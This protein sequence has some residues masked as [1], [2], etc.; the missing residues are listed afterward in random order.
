[1]QIINVNENSHVAISLVVSMVVGFAHAQTAMSPLCM[2]EFM[3]PNL[4]W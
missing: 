3:Y 4:L 1:V 2:H